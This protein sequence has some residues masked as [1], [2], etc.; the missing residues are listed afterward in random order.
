MIH[1]FQYLIIRNKRL[2]NK[3][4]IINKVAVVYE[5]CSAY[6]KTFRDFS[7]KMLKKR[8]EMGKYLV[9]K[10]KIGGLLN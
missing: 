8:I 10:K 7:R 5:K 3:N 9:R 2:K 6:L 1:C 4:K